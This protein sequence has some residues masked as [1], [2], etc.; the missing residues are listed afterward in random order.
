MRPVG[1][2]TATLMLD[3]LSAGSEEALAAAEAAV[4]AGFSDASVWS[5]HIDAVANAALRVDVIEAAL[6]WAGT[7]VDAAAREADHF[8]DL[9]RVHGATQV[10]AITLDRELPDPALAARNLAALA[11]RVSEAGASVCLEFFAWSAVPDLAT[12]WQLIEP[13]P[14]VGIILDTLHWQ[15][16]PGGPA[17]DVLASIPGDRITYVQLSDAAAE[18]DGDR[19]SEALSGRLLPGDGVI[20]FGALFD[21]LDDIGASPFIAT[22][23]FRPALVEELGPGGAAVAMRDAVRSILA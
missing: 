13:L 23:I 4:A 6:A 14:G 7:D 10:A 19:A 3:P 16:Q 21:V 9:A 20:D 5:L 12:A 2:C 8:A 17:F 18:P 15:R 22:E 1:I 11:A